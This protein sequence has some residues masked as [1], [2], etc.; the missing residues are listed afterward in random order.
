MKTLVICDVDGTLT[1]NTVYVDA[2]G[3]ESLRFNKRD[4]WLIGDASRAGVDVVLVTSEPSTGPAKARARK[5]DVPIHGWYVDV[6]PKAELVRSRKASGIHIVYI[7][8]DRTDVDAMRAADEA[9]CPDDAEAV[10]SPP[11]TR[12]AVRGGEGVLH[13]VLRML[14]ERA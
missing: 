10:C 2:N 4:G 11:A 14:L 9:F 6:M 7:G 1:D 3:N 12:L 13:A 8:N 5:L